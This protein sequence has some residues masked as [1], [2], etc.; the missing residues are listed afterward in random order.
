MN[1][2]KLGIFARTRELIKTTFSKLQSVPEIAVVTPSIEA[3]GMQ[4]PEA[5]IKT[6]DLAKLYLGYL[7]LVRDATNLTPID[8]DA[9]DLA[10]KVITDSSADPHTTREILT[11]LGSKYRPEMLKLLIRSSD[12]KSPVFHAALED[13][14]ARMETASE[15]KMAGKDN[16]DTSPDP[17]AKYAIFTHTKEGMQPLAKMHVVIGHGLTRLLTDHLSKDPSTAKLAEKKDYLLHIIGDAMFVKF[18]KAEL[19]IPDHAGKRIEITKE[20]QAI[21]DAWTKYPK[22]GGLHWASLERFEEVKKY[23]TKAY[24]KK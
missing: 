15:R 6:A 20:D 16:S 8:L 9:I 17:E 4:T 2:E 10:D 5:P 23:I 13:L 1:Q 12:L 19:N 22:D 18:A 24:I 14:S 3:M 21:F 7:H 11:T